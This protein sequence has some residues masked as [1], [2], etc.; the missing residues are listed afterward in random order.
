MIMSILPIESVCKIKFEISDSFNMISG[1]VPES[2]YHYT[3]ID[4]LYRIIKD[5]E[6]SLTNSMYLNDRL[7]FKEFLIYLCSVMKDVNEDQIFDERISLL[8]H[9]IEKFNSN[10]RSEYS[11]LSYYILST[12]SKV[13]TLPMWNYYSK[14]EG[15]CIEFDENELSSFF[16]S[17]TNK[18]EKIKY[19]NYNCIYY[20]DDKI[21]FLKSAINRVKN[22][23]KNYPLDG[24]VT[25]WNNLLKYSY[26]FKNPIFDYENERRFVFEVDSKYLVNGNIE[27]NLNIGFYSHKDT[28]KPCLKI[29]GKLPIKAIHLSPM[30]NNETAVNGIKIFL[31]L[32]GYEN[33]TVSKDIKGTR[34]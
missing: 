24:N 32:N 33:V 3:S 27:E 18:S 8:K 13:G 20:E 4:A 7:E 28:I 23:V 34:E 30:N 26:S 11:H 10:T 31:K 2:I 25:L 6:L 22:I 16:E 21:K 12:C 15:V 29:S 5:N 1:D 14:G 17:V 9:E 19:Y